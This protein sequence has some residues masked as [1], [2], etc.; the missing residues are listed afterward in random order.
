MANEAQIAFNPFPG[1]YPFSPALKAREFGKEAALKHFKAAGLIV[2]D[3]E[4]F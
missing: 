1:N 4:S 3:G 2:Q